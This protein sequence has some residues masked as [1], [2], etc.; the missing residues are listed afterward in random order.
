MK[1]KP[2][3][4][5][6][7]L[8]LGLITSTFGSNTMMINADT[9]KK[10]TY[11]KLANKPE[12]QTQLND[13]L[14]KGAELVNQTEPHTALWFALK[15]NHDFAIFDVFFDE[16]GRTQHFAGQVAKA[17]KDNAEQLI[18]GGWDQGVLKNINNYDLIAANHFDKKMVLTSK[19]ASYIVFK[20]KPGKSQ[21]VELF[22]KTAASLINSTEPKT[23]LWV[24]LKTNEDTFAILDTFPN[25]EAQNAHFSGEVAGKLKNNAEALIEGGWEKG[26]LAHVENFQIIASS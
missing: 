21:E 5:T 4:T 25:K 19:E 22:L 15:G 10:A 17:L 6:C 16:Q 9:I 8:T 14:Q 11:I 7:A 13:F 24:A 23:Y 3:L 2:L 1:I 12:S 26:I 20:A 18:Q